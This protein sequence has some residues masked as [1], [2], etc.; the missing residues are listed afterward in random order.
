MTR[1]RADLRLCFVGDS[2]VLGT[3]DSDYL[4]WPGRLC[5]A[6]RRA[7]HDVTCYNLG[8]RRDS[9]ADIAARWRDEVRRRLPAGSDGRVVF[10]F[11]VNDT[12]LV[13]GR[14]RLTLEQSL[15]NA[16]TILSEA[17][18]AYPTL[19]VGPPAVARADQNDRIAE[20]SEHFDR[21][22]R[23]LGVPYLA[24]VG[25]LR[26]SPVWMND[27]AATDGTHPSAAGY[28]EWARLIEQWPAW[29]A[30]LG[31]DAPRPD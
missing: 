30:W 5:V 29:R 1:S 20:L 7:G 9:S 18:R 8:I 15:E 31:T 3:G 2:L 14:R 11:G 25:P 10:S 4:G 6:A 22:C 19:M 13:D 26:A 21:L 23:E 24:V 16:R 12:A 28:A 27:L 17:S